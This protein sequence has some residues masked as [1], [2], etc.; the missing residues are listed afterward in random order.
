M[1]GNLSL[2]PEEGAPGPAPRAVARSL[3]GLSL[4]QS[5]SALLPSPH[6]AGWD[7]EAHRKLCDRGLQESLPKQG[8]APTVSGTM[9]AFPRRP[10]IPPLT[11]PVKQTAPKLGGKKQHFT[12]FPSSLGQEF[13]G[14]APWDGSCRSTVSGA[15]AGR[16]GPGGD[17]RAGPGPLEAAGLPGLVLWLWGPRACGFHGAAR[18]LRAGGRC[19]A[20]ND[21]ASEVTQGHW[22][23][24]Q[25]RGRE[26]GPHL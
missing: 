9:C 23:C 15:P 26:H 7:L 22:L 16:W 3:P 1:P 6:N 17:S 13:R 10:P 20:F 12:M 24:S 2:L 25:P 14:R 4:G 21:P 19:V 5:T 18:A 8:A 11:V